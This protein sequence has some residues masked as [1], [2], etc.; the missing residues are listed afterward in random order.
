[1]SE[2][3]IVFDNI[4]FNLQRAGGVSR[5]WSKI[6]TPFNDSKNVSFI[7]R[8]GAEENIYRSS[9]SLSPI[10]PDHFLPI[11]LSRYL[12]F[13]HKFYNDKYIFHSSYF[14]V[15]SSSDCV[16]VTTVHDLIYEK[17]GRGLGA[18]MHLRQKAIALKKS[19]CIVCVSENTRKDLLEYYPFC[20]DKKVVVIP[21]GVGKLNFSGESAN[22]IDGNSAANYGSYFLY[23][24]HRGSCK[25]FNLIYD[26]LD[27]LDDSLK[28]IVVGEPFTQSEFEEIQARNHTENIINVGKVSDSHLNILYQSANFFFFPSLYEGFGIPPLEAME[29]GCPVLASNRSSIPEVVGDAGVLF[30]PLDLGTLNNG[31]SRV[32]RA[33]VKDELIV[34]GKER[35]NSFSWEL[36][37]KRYE[38]LY[39]EL[40]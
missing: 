9:M 32:M 3:P 31:L 12:N 33:D 37:V 23:V 2:V 34:L 28:C 11:N 8:Y 22:F 7:E 20:A 24:G 5:V 36:V 10:L 17:F 30:D 15:N 19:D 13:S 18:L 38:A 26:V 21:N 25:G 4:V 1:M 16:N 39:S 40:I 14:R 29:A 35:V 27:M 6:I